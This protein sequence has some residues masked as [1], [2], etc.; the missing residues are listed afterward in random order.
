[1]LCAARI[2][3]RE[4]RGAAATGELQYPRVLFMASARA[5]RLRES[6]PRGVR[7]Q[8]GKREGFSFLILA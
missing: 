5:A 3:R 8:P 7:P 1:M 2:E 6:R 4:S